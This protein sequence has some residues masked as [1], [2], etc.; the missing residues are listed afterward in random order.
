VS[1]KSVPAVKIDNAFNIIRKYYK[2]CIIVSHLDQ[3]KN[4]FNYSY[5]ITKN[6]KTNDSNIIMN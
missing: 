4:N 2:W 5:N 3:I 1:F 6:N